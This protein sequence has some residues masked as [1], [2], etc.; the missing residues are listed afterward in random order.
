[1]VIFPFFVR[2]RRPEARARPTSN[3][4]TEIDIAANGHPPA[5]VAPCT[6]KAQFWP[7]FGAHTCAERGPMSPPILGFQYIGRRARAGCY[8]G[9][10]ARWLLSAVWLLRQYVEGNETRSREDTLAQTSQC[11]RSADR[12]LLHSYLRQIR[13]ILCA[14][15]TQF[16]VF[17]PVASWP[18]FRVT[19]R[20]MRGSSIGEPK[21]GRVE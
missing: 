14:R 8:R 5:I 15:P 3:I 4:S 12:G 16:S 1:M 9:V 20:C 2:A 7:I 18:R 11:A 19:V 13:W 17:I 21:S 6:G 10:L